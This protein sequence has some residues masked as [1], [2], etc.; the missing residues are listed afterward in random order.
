MKKQDYII[1][2][3]SIAIVIVLYSLFQVN[4]KYNKLSESNEI[5]NKSL[6]IEKDDLINENE[7]LINMSNELMEDIM[8]I[9]QSL[10]ELDKKLNAI[11]IKSHEK[12]S[13]IRNITDVDSLQWLVSSR[14]KGH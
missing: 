8:V 14:Y 12:K 6:E 1:I 10:Y 9:N 13:T 11:N 3:L 4:S 2:A 7:K 5:I